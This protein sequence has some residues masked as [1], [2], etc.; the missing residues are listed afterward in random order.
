MHLIWIIQLWEVMLLNSSE[1]FFR[2]CA[3]SEFLD[4]LEDVLTSQHT[5]PVVRERFLEVLSVAAD[6]SSGTPCESSFRVL[7]RKVKPAE[8]PDEVGPYLLFVGPF[9]C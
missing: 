8:M 1:L 3:R 4:T 7:L 2:Q 9:K 6:A 5:S